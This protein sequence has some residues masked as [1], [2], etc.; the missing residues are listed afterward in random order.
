MIDFKLFDLLK[1]LK[2]LD[3]DIKR[4]LDNNDLDASECRTLCVS[5]VKELAEVNQAIVQS[6]L[7]S[8]STMSQY[9]ELAQLN[10]R[11][12]LLFQRLVNLRREELRLDG[13]QYDVFL[14]HA[15]EE[16][17]YYVESQL[18]EQLSRQ[19]SR[20]RVFLDIVSITPDRF[21][22]NDIA[23]DTGLLTSR[24][25]L[26]VLSTS[27]LCSPWP[28]YEFFFTSARR[29]CE[30]NTTDVLVD[31]LF[32]PSVMHDS[33]MFNLVKCLL[34]WTDMPPSL[35]SRETRLSVHVKNVI[36]TLQRM[37][38]AKADNESTTAVASSPAAATTSLVST[39]CVA[40]SRPIALYVLSHTLVFDLLGM[41]APCLSLTPDPLSLVAGMK[42]TALVNN[43]D[44]TAPVIVIVQLPAEMSDST[45]RNFRALVTSLRQAVGA[46]PILFFD[47]TP[48]NE[49]AARVSRADFLDSSFM[50]QLIPAVVFGGSVGETNG[51]AMHSCAVAVKSAR[52]RM[53]I[54]YAPKVN[55]VDRLFAISTCWLSHNHLN[56]ELDDHAFIAVHNADGDIEKDRTGFWNAFKAEFVHI[57]KT[58][59]TMHYLI[60]Q[61]HV[62]ALVACL[63]R[64]GAW[65]SFLDW[66][67]KQEDEVSVLGLPSAKID[68]SGVKSLMT[69]GTN[70]VEIFDSAE[71]FARRVGE[72]AWANDANW[73]G[74]TAMGKYVVMADSTQVDKSPEATTVVEA[75]KDDDEVVDKIAFEV[76][77]FENKLD[78]ANVDEAVDKIAEGGVQQEVGVLRSII[79]LLTGSSSSSSRSRHEDHFLNAA[80]FGQTTLLAHMLSLKDFDPSFAKSRAIRVAAENGQTEAVRLLLAD[81]RLDPTAENNA[82]LRFAEQNQHAA[83][84][85]LL[86]SDPRVNK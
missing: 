38:N 41:L 33:T 51:D 61:A 53:A 40:F 86:R 19:G 76:Q 65:V 44:A 1:K 50:P 56:A 83:V 49:S 46:V 16:K 35:L 15:G 69:L 73:V 18:H 64:C 84:V 24:I 48:G 28:L 45:K 58:G 34:P 32:D 52:S 39:T 66:L 27:F 59:S 26:L 75:N 63:V 8:Q 80:R 82:A 30:F 9:G 6:E 22:T 67:A 20:W 74:G 4:A 79:G 62:G 36:D 31:I 7:E 55:R 70:G 23:V 12:Q 37:L 47:E 78:E 72:T 81:I 43:A 14:A 17:R 85:A 5:Y 13:F 3:N 21:S 57:V 71:D 42:L 25:I 54:S 68:S 77:Q 2:D 11:A 10:G 60:V 29:D